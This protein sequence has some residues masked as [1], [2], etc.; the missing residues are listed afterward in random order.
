L[1][2]EPIDLARIRTT[3]GLQTTL[4]SAGRRKRGIT[5]VI[6]LLLNLIGLYFCIG[7]APIAALL[8]KAFTG[9]VEWRERSFPIFLWPYLLV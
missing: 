1:K 3:Y 7:D 2:H 6:T 8:H 5:A 9:G 4:I